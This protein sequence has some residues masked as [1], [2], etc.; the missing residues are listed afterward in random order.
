MLA[1]ADNG[2]LVDFPSAEVTPELRSP[3]PPA[4]RLLIT[5]DKSEV[6]ARRV[7]YADPSVF[8]Q[9]L[10]KAPLISMPWRAQLPDPRRYSG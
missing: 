5:D 1:P 2:C 7:G 3:P 6:V 10:R 8:R 9:R 4:R